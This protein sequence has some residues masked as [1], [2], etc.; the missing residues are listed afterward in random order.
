MLKPVS[1]LNSVS[2]AGCA[3]LLSSLERRRQDNRKIFGI[4]LSRTGTTSLHRALCLLGFRSIHYPPLHRL[5]HLLQYHDAAMD[6]PV[7]CSFR[8]MDILYPNS[9]FILTVRDSRSWLKSTKLFFARHPAN[10]EWQREV[11]LKIYGVVEWNRR[12]F[13]DAYNRHTE[14]VLDY[15]ADRPGQLL[16]LDICAGEGWDKLCPFLEMP[17]PNTSFPHA[18]ARF[19]KKLGGKSSPRNGL[20]T[21]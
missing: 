17:A 16:I 10:A 7:A 13:L 19:K 18:N 14:A 8:E 15:F 4:G 9:Q 3:E 21:T 5:K 1:L 2:D 20:L 6:T 11:R 12:A